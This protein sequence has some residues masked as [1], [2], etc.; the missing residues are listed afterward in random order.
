MGIYYGRLLR[1]KIRSVGLRPKSQRSN[2]FEAFR[3]RIPVD[4]II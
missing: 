1:G 4:S 3:P 2:N